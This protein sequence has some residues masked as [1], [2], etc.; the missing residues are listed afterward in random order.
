MKI[1]INISVR[2]FCTDSK[3]AHHQVIGDQTFYNGAKLAQNLKVSVTTML[4]I[5]SKGA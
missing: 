2:T 4:V 1:S 3:Q 5:Q